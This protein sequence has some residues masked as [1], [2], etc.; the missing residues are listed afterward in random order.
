MG[1]VGLVGHRRAGLGAHLPAA[2]IERVGERLRDQRRL[3]AA[4]ALLGIG[5]RGH[6]VTQIATRV[7]QQRGDRPARCVARRIAVK[8]RCRE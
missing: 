8:G 2:E 5:C 4:I 7:E 3:R 1:W 6:E